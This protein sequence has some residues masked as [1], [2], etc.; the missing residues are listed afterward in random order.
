MW[1]K[2]IVVWSV[3]RPE[4]ETCKT[5]PIY[6]SNRAKRTQFVP[7]QVADERDCAKRSQTWV[8]W[9]IWAKAIIVWGVARLESETCKTNPILAARQGMGAGWPAARL[10]WR[11]IVQNKANFR[12][13]QIEANCRPEKRL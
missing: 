2:V 1:A 7:E 4:S 3:A 10:R 8:D 12:R 6:A 13:D 5:K 9:S 11:A